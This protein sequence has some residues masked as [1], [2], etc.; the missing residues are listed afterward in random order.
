MPLGGAVPFYTVSPVLAAAVLRLI[1]IP[2]LSC[3]CLGNLVPT[4]GFEPR[5]Y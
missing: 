4:R 5:T 3:K 1:P 2:I